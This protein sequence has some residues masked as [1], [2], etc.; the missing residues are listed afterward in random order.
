MSSNPNQVKP[1]WLG[2]AVFYEIY[3]QS[4]YD[5]NGDG[6]GDFNGITEKLPYIRSAAQRA[7]SRAR[8]SPRP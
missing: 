8:R 3:P 6:I 4:Y 2:D 1:V 7:C 5:T